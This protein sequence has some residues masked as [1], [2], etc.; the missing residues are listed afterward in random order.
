MLSTTYLPILEILDYFSFK[1]INTT[2][3]HTLWALYNFLQLSPFMK[4]T[5]YSIKSMRKWKNDAERHVAAY[6]NESERNMAEKWDDADK[7]L[8]QHK[9]LMLKD[10][11]LYKILTLKDLSLYKGFK[12]GLPAFRFKTLNETEISF[13]S[14][15]RF[16]NILFTFNN[17][18]NETEKPWNAVYG[19]ISISSHI[20]K[21]NA[22]PALEVLAVCRLEVDIEDSLA[23]GTGR[24]EEK[25][26]N[27]MENTVRTTLK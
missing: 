2:P 17:T 5:H 12:L 11:S 20:F 6:T 21:Y 22:F 24:D 7:D 26:V 1:S 14:R 13:R 16:L 25:A 19:Q 15:L 8:S 3:K 9:G 23:S 18:V 10:L 4:K 27:V